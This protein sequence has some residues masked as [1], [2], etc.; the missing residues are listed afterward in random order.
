MSEP[1]VIAVVANLVALA[2]HAGLGFYWAGRIDGRLV[3]LEHRLDDL[4]AARVRTARALEDH[5]REHSDGKW[6]RA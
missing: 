4:H 2:V 5:V 3:L 6:S 1:A